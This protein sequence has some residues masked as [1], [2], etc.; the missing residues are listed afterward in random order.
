MQTGVL[1]NRLQKG[2]MEVNII[3]D[4]QGFDIYKLASQGYCCTQILMILVLQAE[5][6]ENYDLIRAANGMC[7]GMQCQGTCG[8]ISGIIMAFGLYAGRGRPEDE[9]SEKLRIM[10][11]EFTNWF[12]EEYKSTLCRELVTVDIFTDEGEEVYPVKCGEII[13]KAYNKMK[14]ILLDHDYELGERDNGE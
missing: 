6:R 10:S 3:M 9:R 2:L 5:G 1:F 12:K 8:A 4:M 14:D 13:L 11:E 7:V